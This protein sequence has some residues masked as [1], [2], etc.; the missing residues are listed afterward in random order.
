MNFENTKEIQE[1]NEIISE[2]K[3][4]KTKKNANKNASYL[5]KGIY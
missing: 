4:K 3:S 2:K 1:K 5:I